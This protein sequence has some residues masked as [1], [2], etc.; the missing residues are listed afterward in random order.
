METQRKNIYSYDNHFQHFTL[1]M[2]KNKQTNKYVHTI[3]LYYKLLYILSYINNKRK[4]AHFIFSKYLYDR[5]RTRA[6]KK[7]ITLIRAT[8]K[9]IIQKSLSTAMWGPAPPISI[10]PL[11]WVNSLSA[12]N[13]FHFIA[14]ATSEWKLDEKLLW[15][16]IFHLITLKFHYQFTLISDNIDSNSLYRP[17]LV[18]TFFPFTK[19][20][21]T[22]LAV[23]FDILPR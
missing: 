18:F 19:N 9:N 20:T 7:K 15:E 3:F 14:C 23:V 5:L 6:K 17:K 4:L 11:L 22:E 21:K 8:T 13:Q 1:S 10:D 12:P 16:S 2:K